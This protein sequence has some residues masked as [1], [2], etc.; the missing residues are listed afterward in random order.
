MLGNLLENSYK[1]RGKT[2][3]PTPGAPSPG[4]RAVPGARGQRTKPPQATTNGRNSGAGTAPAGITRFLSASPAPRRQ[5][6]RPARPA[7]APALPARSARPPFGRSL[8][9]PRRLRKKEQKKKTNKK[10]QLSLAY[11]TAPGV[12]KR[13]G[14]SPAEPP[15]TPGPPPPTP[16]PRQNRDRSP[17]SATFPK[18]P[19]RPPT[20]RFPQSGG[21]EG[22]EKRLL[23]CP[24]GDRTRPEKREKPHRLGSGGTQPPTHPPLRCR[25]LP[26]SRRRA[27]QRNRAQAPKRGAA[28]TS[29]GGGGSARCPGAAPDAPAAGAPRPP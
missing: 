21:G 26:R 22:D 3:P 8:G 18:F 29:G 12:G 7:G 17:S 9:V 28:P 10:T 16:S 13:A 11:P 2:R 5:H 27:P 24:G 14:L 19:S 25:Q 23:T 6:P 15:G 20:P 4:E 1:H